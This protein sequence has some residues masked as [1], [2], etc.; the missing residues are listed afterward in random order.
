MRLYSDADWLTQQKG[1]E[2][3]EELLKLEIGVKLLRCHDDDVAGTLSIS[4]Q[5][6]RKKKWKMD[7]SIHVGACEHFHPKHEL[8]QVFL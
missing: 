8:S 3:R 6:E 1:G 7:V 5:S 4:E 2:K